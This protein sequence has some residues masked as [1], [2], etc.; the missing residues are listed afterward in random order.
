MADAGV[1]GR[2][3]ARAS[4]HCGLWTCLHPSGSLMWAGSLS[5][6]KCNGLM[7]LSNRA[8]SGWLAESEGAVCS[9]RPFCGVGP[10]VRH[11]QAA[12]HPGDWLVRCGAAWCRALTLNKLTNRPGQL[13]PAPREDRN[14][15]RSWPRT[16]GPPARGGACESLIRQAAR[17]CTQRACPDRCP[18]RA[19]PGGPQA[20]AAGALQRSSSC[21]PPAS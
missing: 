6:P 14:R 5:S 17:R 16:P 3:E 19:P 11:L 18:Q 21:W 9:G 10:H 4:T 8:V 1:F 20:A 15:A 13:R 7:E 12:L 2:R